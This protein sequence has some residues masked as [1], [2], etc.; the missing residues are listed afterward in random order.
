MA[1][2]LA[3]FTAA[4]R[5]G[6]AVSR[7]G[8]VTAASTFVYLTA[9]GAA[10]GGYFPGSWGWLTLAAAWAA[11]LALVLDGEA[12]LSRAELAF[13]GLLGAYTALVVP[14]GAVEQRRDPDRCCRDSATSSTSP[15]SSR[16]CSSAAATPR[17]CSSGVWASAAALCLDALATRLIP[18]RFGVFDQISGYRLSEPIGYWNS[19][20]MLAGD[21]RPGRARLRGALPTLWLRAARRR[22]S[23]PLFTTTLY[24]T[25]SRGAWA[26]LV[27]GVVVLLRGRPAPAAG[28]LVDRAR[29]RGR[30]RSP[31]ALAVGEHAL[32]HGR[33][34]ACGPGARGPLALR[35]RSLVVAVVTGA[36]AFGVRREPGSASRRRSTGSSGAC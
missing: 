23:V 12:A 17:R 8:A 22:R 10:H 35:S 31:S 32:S 21:R 5:A 34:A 7:R 3:P 2:T 18:D 20:G 13:T 33:R 19:L 11:V 4:T 27:A 26:S 14:L 6:T 25:F 1:D 24:F 30:A 36:V 28:A 29:R 16:R 15:A 9:A